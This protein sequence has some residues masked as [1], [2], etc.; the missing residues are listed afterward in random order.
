MKHINH[1]FG[2]ML[3][4]VAIYI[5]GALPAV[6]VLYLWSV[7]F[8]VT[9]VYLGALRTTSNSQDGWHILSKGL[10]V[11]VLVWGVLALLGAMSGSRD[12]LRPVNLANFGQSA[13]NGLTTNTLQES[14]HSLFKRVAS[15]GELDL[16]LGLASDGGKL[17]MLDY[18]ADW[19]VDCIR[20]ENTTFADSNVRQAL[21]NFIMLQV[22]VTDPNNAPTNK[23]KKRYGVY[24]PPAMLFF[25][26]AGNELKGLRRYGYMDA[27]EFV[28]HIKN[29]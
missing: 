26:S 24:G 10:G 18:Y 9:A 25:D 3:L 2:I 15:V 1:A 4:G 23:I 27:A 19:C 13:H 28:E 5:L 7:L 6:P 29:I 8:V 16:E 11:F 20:M 14:S 22:D 17:V 21:E 12:I